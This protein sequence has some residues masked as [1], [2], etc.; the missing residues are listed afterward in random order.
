MT[1]GK[2]E[3]A[4]A[5]EEAMDK[6]EQIVAKLESGDVPLEKAIE[7]F[8]EGMELSHLCGQKLEQVE[9]KIETLL[10]ENGSFV[11]KPF[12]PLPDEKEN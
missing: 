11:K 4:I 6:L 8:Q 1:S 9:R 12:Q 10:E 7:L 5:F 3:N 2:E